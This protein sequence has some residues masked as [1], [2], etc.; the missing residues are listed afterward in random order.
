MTRLTGGSHCASGKGSI[1]KMVQ[2]VALP[3]RLFTW[4]NWSDKGFHL[5]EYEKKTYPLMIRLWQ[6]ESPMIA[7]VSQSWYVTMLTFDARYDWRIDSYQPNEM[8]S[9]TVLTSAPK[10]DRSYSAEVT[11]SFRGMK[12]FSRVIARWIGIRQRISTTHSPTRNWDIRLAELKRSTTRSANATDS[13]V[14]ELKT[15]PVG[16]RVF[17]SKVL[18]KVLKYDEKVPYPPLVTHVIRFG[19]WCIFDVLVR[20]STAASTGKRVHTS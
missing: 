12:R 8:L 9:I 16:F 1:H 3:N 7:S 5:F 18:I 4:L 10:R 2:R 19:E 11:P 15:S 13:T 17:C 20:R 6:A 14:I